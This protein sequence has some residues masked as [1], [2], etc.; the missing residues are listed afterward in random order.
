MESRKWLPADTR[1]RLIDLC[2]DRKITQAQLADV[3]GIDRSALSRFIN[4]KTD[5]MSH[6]YVIRIAKYFNVS[7][8]FVLGE[9]DDPGRINYDI[10]ELGLTV[11]AAECLYTRRVDPSIL[12]RLLEHESCGDLVHKIGLFLDGTLTSGIAAQNQVYYSVIDLLD[13]H[14]SEHPADKQA[15]ATAAQTIRA[16][17][18]PQYTEKD[19]IHSDLDQILLDMKKD[20]LPNVKRSVLLTKDTMKNMTFQMKKGSKPFNLRKVPPKEIVDRII[21]QLNM[22]GIP[23]SVKPEFDRVIVRL[24]EDLT[25]FFNILKTVKEQA[26]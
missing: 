5:S 9:T 13:D 25:D 4:G 2:K 19:G 16:I 14:A 7:T 10:E 15:A 1:T 26:E 24:R 22:A 11:K 3:L 12:C 17:K 21:G 20:S 23:V 8:D 6:E 18:R